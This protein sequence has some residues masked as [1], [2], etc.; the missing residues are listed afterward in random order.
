MAIRKFGQKIISLTLGKVTIPTYYVNNTR[1]SYCSSYTC[2]TSTFINASSRYVYT[3]DP[4]VCL[5]Y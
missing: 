2:C 1:I 3:N 4:Q 5:Y